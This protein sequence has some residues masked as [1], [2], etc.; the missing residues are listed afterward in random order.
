MRSTGWTIA[1]LWLSGCFN[2]MG[3]MGQD[4]SS[5]APDSSSSTSSGEVEPTP[6]TG[7][8]TEAPTTGSDTSDSGSSTGPQDGDECDP[9]APNCPP[10]SKCAAYASNGG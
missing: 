8:T 3:P 1:L 2:D 7:G 10:G 6:T 5:G 4:S 9:W